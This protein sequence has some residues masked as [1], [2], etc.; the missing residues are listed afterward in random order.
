M[1]CAGLHLSFLNN[2]ETTSGYENA[3]FWFGI[4]DGSYLCSIPA[5]SKYLPKINFWFQFHA[6]PSQD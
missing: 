4:V 6:V 2:E 3:K 1:N 5:T